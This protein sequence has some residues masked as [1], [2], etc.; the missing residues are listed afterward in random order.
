MQIQHCTMYTSHGTNVSIVLCCSGSTQNWAQ[1]R[2]TI[3][4]NFKIKT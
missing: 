1:N 2:N 3:N 4:P